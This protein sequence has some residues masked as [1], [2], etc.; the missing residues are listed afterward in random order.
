MNKVSGD[1]LHDAIRLQIE[2][3][4]SFLI[5]CVSSILLYTYFQVGKIIV[6]DEQS[7]KLAII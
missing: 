3:P 6:E 2:E 4:R 5:Q 1:K 7:G